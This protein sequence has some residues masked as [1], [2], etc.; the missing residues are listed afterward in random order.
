[1]SDN[2]V[3]SAFAPDGTIE[4]IEVPAHRFAL[5]LQWHPE[6]FATADNPGNRIFKAFVDEA[7]R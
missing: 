1:M 7:G 4:A 6:A 3:A 2:V 5:G